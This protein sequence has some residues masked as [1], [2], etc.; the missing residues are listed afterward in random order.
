MFFFFDFRSAITENFFFVSHRRSA[1]TTFKVWWSNFRSAIITFMLHFFNN[2]LSLIVPDFCFYCNQPLKEGERCLCENCKKKIPRT[3]SEKPDNEAEHRVFGKFRYEHGASFC[4]Y[5][6]EGDFASL[7]IRAKYLDKPWINYD[8][9]T[10]FASELSPAGWPFDIDLIMP[11]PIHF[12]RRL[13]R[14][15]NQAQPIAEALSKAWKLP[16]DTKNLIKSRYTSSQVTHTGLQRLD[17]LEGPFSLRHPEKLPGRHVLL[18]DDVL[19]T[20]ATLDACAQLLIQAG[21]RV[22]FLTLGLSD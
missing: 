17:A 20:G 15:Y 9:A 7:I 2:L 14:G 19:T 1:I 22:S 10:M 12:L 4:Y 3:R 13:R 16:I 18:V 6:K 11:V 8:L 21:A 5:R